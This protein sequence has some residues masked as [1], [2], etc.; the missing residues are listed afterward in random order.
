MRMGRR[1]EMPKRMIGV[2]SI[3]QRETVAAIPDH[4]VVTARAGRV[5][6]LHLVVAACMAAGFFVKANAAHDALAVTSMADA[7]SV[8]PSGTNLPWE[9][10][11]FGWYL[12]GIGL[13][14]GIGI[15]SVD[16]GTG[17]DYAILN[18]RSGDSLGKPLGGRIE[19]KLDNVD[20][21]TYAAF[22][23]KGSDTVCAGRWDSVGVTGAKPTGIHSVW[24]AVTI[25][26]GAGPVSISHGRGVQAPSF[27]RQPVD[28][29]VG[30]GGAA[31]FIAKAN[32][33]PRPTYQWTK[34]GVNVPGATDTI[35][36]LNG[37]TAASAG[38]Y[39]LVATNSSGSITSNTA[40]LTV[41]SVAP[42][43]VAHTPN[44]ADS[45][46]A[47]YGSITYRATVGAGT[48][49]LTYQWKKNNV[50]LVRTGT[51]TD[52]AYLVLTNLALT[53]S[54]SYSVTVSNTAGSASSTATHLTVQAIA[55][56]VT[57]SPA[58]AT[59][60]APGDTITLR[61]TVTQGSTPFTYQW[62]HNGVSM[63]GRTRDTLKLGSLVYPADTG[64]YRI[65]V[66]NGAGSASDSAR[67]LVQVLGPQVSVFPR[68]D[69]IAVGGTTNFYVLDNGANRP[70]TYT[71]YRVGAG[72][73][74]DNDSVLNLANVQMSQDN[75]VYYAI[76]SNVKSADT[77][78]LCTLRV[79][80]PVAAKFSVDKVSGLAPLAVTFTDSSTG[81]IASWQWIV[82]DGATQS[83]TAANKPAS[84]QHTYVDTG[85][86][87]ARLTVTGIP[88]AGQSSYDYPQQIR[89][90]TLG[91]N[92]IQI[93]ATYVS[94]TV[95]RVTFTGYGTLDSNYPLAPESA[96]S[97]GVWVDQSG[98]RPDTSRSGMRTAYRITTLRSAGTQDV[99]V[100]APSSAAHQTYLLWACPLRMNGLNPYNA[101][102]TTTV[103][104]KPTCAMTVSAAYHGNTGSPTAPVLQPGLLDSATITV[105]NASSLVSAGLTSVEIAYRAASGAADTRTLP[106]ADF[107]AAA[108][109]GSYTWGVSN[110]VFGGDSQTVTASVSLIGANGLR[111]APVSASFV[112]GWPAPAY[113]G[114]LTV[115]NAGVTSV[116]LGWAPA[117]GAD[118]VRILYTTGATP[119][120][121][122]A[123]NPGGTILLASPGP[124]V[125]NVQYIVT[126][127]ADSTTYHF[128][129]QMKKN[130]KWSLVT[131]ACRVSAMTKAVDPQ[132]TV[133]NTT[134]IDALTFDAQ[135]N[136]LSVKWHFVAQPLLTYDVGIVW[137]LDSVAAG[138]TQPATTPASKVVTGAPDSGT[139]VIDLGTGLAFDTTLHVGTWL[140]SQV[141]P[142]SAPSTA[143]SQKSVRTSTANWQCITLFAPDLV[144]LFNGKAYVWRDPSSPF[145]PGSI[146]TAKYVA[147]ITTLSGYTM[148]GSGFSL[149]QGVPVPFYIGIVYT[150]V[151]SGYT[152][153]DVG[154]YRDSAGVLM[155]VHGSRDTTT[156]MGTMVYAKIS[157]F[158]GT[159]NSGRNIPYIAAVDQTTPTVTPQADLSTTVPSGQSLD[160]TINV[161]D[162][163][164][165]I[166]WQLFYAKDDET[167]DAASRMISGV[168]CGD[169]NGQPGQI[170]A[171]VPARSVSEYNGVR[172]IL[173]VSDGAH[174]DTFD[175]SRR[176]TRDSTSDAYST[177]AM[178]WTPIWSTAQLADSSMVSN[179][180]ELNATG[181]VWAYDNK[182]FRIFRW[183][184]GAYLEYSAD[185]ASSFVLSPGRLLWL[186]TR[187][188]LPVL[189]LGP[190]TTLPLNQPVAF[191][192]PAR[193]FADIGMP[194]RNFKVCV[195]DILDSTGV[196]K[197]NLDVYIWKA[198][199]V[200]NSPSYRLE[201]LFT[202]RLGSKAVNDSSAQLDGY[203]QAGYA[204]YNAGDANLPVRIPA[205]PADGSRYVLGKSALS[206]KQ[207]ANR[208]WSYTVTAR[209]ASGTELSPVYCGFT[210]SPSQTTYLPYAP[211]FLPVGAGVYDRAGSTVRGHV[212]VHCL[213][214]GGFTT[215]LAL[216][217]T[218][219]KPETFQCRL[220]G[221]ADIPKDF[222]AHVLDPTSGQFLDNGETFEVTV[223]AN[224][225]EYRV[226]AVGSSTY[227]AG[228]GSRGA[229]A[230]PK[231]LGCYPNPFA[232]TVVVR[233][234]APAYRTQRVDLS[235]YDLHGMLVRRE[236]QT[237]VASGRVIWNAL[238]AQQ[239]PVSQGAYVVRLEMY[240]V[241]GKAFGKFQTRVTCVR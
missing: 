98:G 142:W 115:I 203:A 213:D 67:I 22:D 128:A 201:L 194:F 89:A 190:A 120:P 116:T 107:I 3:A 87:T 108:A 156:A 105:S 193:D 209:T 9:P 63:T 42:S 166:L 59:T 144:P 54:G 228:L 41:N 53:D 77:T 17:V 206:T 114:R 133:V 18:Y 195:G 86:Y 159:G 130:Q 24:V 180:D 139:T 160:Y 78:E 16:F 153:Q 31:T 186:K 29:T 121:I 131:D 229:F 154:L 43:G 137:S 32:G 45:V 187:E 123:A 200:A 90:A 7:D 149:D 118:E 119:I 40:T 70:L 35:L 197:E 165:N 184:K 192:V 145:N 148:V 57:V 33:F 55:P 134:V 50:A 225:Q 85:L 88:P 146:D 207:S 147:P 170:R 104:M 181:G 64:S 140:R 96:D 179:F 172:A 129:V 113:A 12:R 208:G 176:T 27:T 171:T 84:I 221:N 218:S 110:G 46:A 230:K 124:S 241:K 178:E 28:V 30:D 49:P 236:T 183:V 81:S 196:S 150:D 13:G 34:D 80:Q 189:G 177:R 2:V 214:N 235:V 215:E 219:D 226:L 101:A 136:Q 48:P 5:C 39:R 36:T 83:Y 199:T 76:V 4:R 227:L 223:P 112:V 143:S 23:L 237:N 125:A 51:R 151:P 52:S 155:A 191:S 103:L 216:L 20:G 61:G 141:G 238:D 58:G 111:S 69:T 164:G 109:S 212:S 224:S 217:N 175:L 138:T 182:R 66:T 75:A 97:I 74:A 163:T 94:Q 21:R 135:T 240:D 205:V 62:Y 72:A 174:L 234:R 157:D 169:C 167:W 14:I 26:P 95:V 92:P 1:G 117:T 211:S 210:E 204:L 233:F 106:V 60:R 15:D 231:L 162:N 127:L 99:T 71:W 8:F 10:C 37:V 158:M 173:V 73:V 161:D 82:G 188:P 56:K 185:V 202:S 122:G 93:T 19:F 152:W 198:A 102:N 6:A 79:V 132:A 47:L 25:N 44:K 11:G 222:V 68:K 232:G 38:A 65:T 100:P 126:G 239:R 91:A 220:V 168:V